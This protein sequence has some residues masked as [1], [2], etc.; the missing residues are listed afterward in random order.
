MHTEVPPAY[1][2]RGIA[3]K[4]NIAALKYAKK[5][6]FKVRSYCSYTTMYIERHPEYKVLL[7]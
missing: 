3:A 2:G 5:E 7:G 6:G 4:L 1:E